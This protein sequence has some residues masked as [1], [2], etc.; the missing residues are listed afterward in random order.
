MENTDF[1]SHSKDIKDCTMVVTPA[2]SEE[3]IIFRRAP[4]EFVII[5]TER[6]SIP[7]VVDTPSS[8]QD[9]EDMPLETIKQIWALKVYK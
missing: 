6:R 7:Y 8:I 2:P 1:I 5:P 3:F 9:A 4:K